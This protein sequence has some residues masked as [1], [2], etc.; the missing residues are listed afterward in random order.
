[1][2]ASLAATIIC[3][4]LGSLLSLRRALTLEPAVVFK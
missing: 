2:A 3:V 4:G 1:M